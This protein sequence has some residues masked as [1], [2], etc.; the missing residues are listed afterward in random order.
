M[1]G[2]WQSFW[3]VVL[4]VPVLIW[5]ALAYLVTGNPEAATPAA[6]TVIVHPAEPEP[7]PPPSP[8]GVDSAYTLARAEALAKHVGLCVWIDCEPQRGLFPSRVHV[9]VKGP[10][11]LI[12]GPAVAICEYRYTLLEGPWLEWIETRRL[13]S[14]GVP[15][16]A[17][18]SAPRFEAVARPAAS[19]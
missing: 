13:N 9:R 1:H 7:A 2:F 18:P 14:Q 16:S 12:S 4:I 11:C 8:K 5:H 6:W 3:F 15:V 17:Q 10:F 19:C